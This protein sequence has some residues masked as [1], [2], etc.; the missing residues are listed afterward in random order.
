MV[1]RVI[2]VIVLVGASLV[3]VTAQQREAISVRGHWLLK[4]FTP[5][6]TLT[7]TREFDNALSPEGQHDL[8]KV[9]TGRN[10]FGEWLIRLKGP[11]ARTSP[12]FTNRYAGDFDGHIVGANSGSADYIEGSF[13]TLTV[14]VGAGV[15]LGG[16]AVAKQ[17]GDLTEV[18]TLTNLCAPFQSHCST[19][20][21]GTFRKFSG[22]L[23]APLRLEAGQIV[24]V[25]VTISF[26]AAP[27][28]PSD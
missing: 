2:A 18:Q 11:S 22:T 20:Y 14:D 4:V 27:H 19:N 10:N 15:V 25:T 6:G 23:I 9:L 5:D 17:S 3:P 24:Q 26:A 16:S 13:R 28:P 12:F 21:Y 8:V 1:T 7:A